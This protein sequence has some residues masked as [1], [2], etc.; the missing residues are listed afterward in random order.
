MKLTD[1]AYEGFRLGEKSTVK[2][3]NV[4]IGQLLAVFD[5]AGIR[6]EKTDEGIRWWWADQSK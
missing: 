6:I 4:L 5:E 3:A 1:A 2:L